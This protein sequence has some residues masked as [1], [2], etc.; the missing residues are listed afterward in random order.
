MVT[1]LGSSEERI[2]S[3]SQSIFSQSKSRANDGLAAEQSRAARQPHRPEPARR[4]VQKDP[5]AAAN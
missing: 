5:P 3:G 2:A 1:I 4:M